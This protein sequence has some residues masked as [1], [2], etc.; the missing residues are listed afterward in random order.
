LRRV[1]GRIVTWLRHLGT[2][3]GDAGMVL[4]L[5]ALGQFSI[6]AGFTNEGPRGLT[7][8]VALVA[9]L[10]LLARRRAPVA[11][12]AVV[13]ALWA[14]QSIAAT[15]PS[16]LWELIVLLLVAYA[17][18]AYADGRRAI[19]GGL[20]V[21]AGVT[22][23][24]AF[25]TAPD[26]SLFTPLVLGGGPWVAGRL[27]RRYSGRARELARV[28][29]ELERRR[30]DDVRAQV[31]EE[32]ARIAREL[33]DV[34]AHSISVM[35]V[36]AGA[37]EQLAGSDPERLAGSLHAIRASG[38]NALAEM[39]RL[40]GVLRTDPGHLAFEP[41]P[42]LRDLPALVDQMRRA[43]LDVGL[44]MPGGPVDLAPGPGLA[45]YRVIQEALTNVLKH[46]GRTR[47]AVAVRVDAGHV[48]LEVTN[49][50][51]LAR[52]SA[53]GGHGLIGMRERMLLY[54]G[55]VEAGPQANGGWAV[56]ARLPAGE[57]AS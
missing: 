34:V 27:A 7:V 40:V 20:I 37:A 13:M 47:A 45:A 53:N 6:W 32:R 4:A 8:P 55:I 12:A 41:Q 56:H 57:D 5:C 23:D 28:N 2:R 48:E 38:K 10:A 35:V 30:E 9:T 51:P 16:A 31:Q 36:Q 33:H 22:V 19:A 44:E 1:L 17:P 29:A 26:A 50:G 11:V 25:E 14:A 3:A 18:G 39:R 49:D 46:A 21:L 54:G 43:G 15:S 52:A 24:V 42:G